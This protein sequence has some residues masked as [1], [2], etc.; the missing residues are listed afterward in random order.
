MNATATST[1][2]PISPNDGKHIQYGMGS[3][4]AKNKKQLMKEIKRIAFMDAMAPKLK[5]DGALAG[6]HCLP[7]AP[8]TA[9]VLPPA[10]KSGMNIR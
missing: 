9:K 1:I 10:G 6:F 2:N 3:E 7:Q 8:H 4:N 5:S